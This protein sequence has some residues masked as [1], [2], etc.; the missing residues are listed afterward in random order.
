M[1]R[2]TCTELYAMRHISGVFILILISFSTQGQNL[3]DL[4]E[5][6]EHAVEN[7]ISIQQANLNVDLAD[8]QL[9]QAKQARYPSLNANSGLSW[10]FGRTVDPT[11]NDFNT[12]TFFAN[13]ISLN[14]GIMLFNGGRIRNTIKQTQIDREAS[15][16]DAQQMRNDISLQVAN[17]YLNVLFAKENLSIAQNQY[18]LSLE[19]L[20][21]IDKLINAGARPSNERLDLE[22]Q[23]ATQEQ[24]IVQA[25]NNLEIALLGIKQ[26]LQ[27]DPNANFEVENPGEAIQ[28]TLDPEL[29]SLEEIYASA[30][31]TQLNIQSQELKNES[32]LLGI[33]VA[34]SAYFPSL[35][36]GGSVGTNYSNRGVRVD[37]FTDEIINQTIFINGNETT[38]GFPQSFPILS[39]NPYTNQLDENLSYGFGLQLNIP[40]YNNYSAKGNV[41]RAKINALNTQLA[42]EQIKNTLKSNVQQAL[43]NA[44]A[45]KRQF[46]V[47]EKSV[48]AQN[49]SFSN[50][51]KRFDLGAIN[52]FDYV[53]AKNQLDNA[54]LNLLIAKYDYIFKTKV[55]DFYLGNPIRLK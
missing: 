29:I 30:L 7:N 3:W 4:R 12:E 21:Q 9:K 28:V 11:S 8:I 23:L 48:L 38:V 42:G 46:D 34:K 19:Q 16:K 14:S 17:S 13:T 37:G 15:M 24:R 35:S 47:S 1:F 6:I 39:D 44:K 54:E 33:D 26:L 53:N 49:A 50:A 27:L 45:A 41:E 20:N 40:I 43:A 2:Y 22:A 55:L 32:A 5:C 18:S 36:F 31:K 25:E 51:Q 10:N 52:T